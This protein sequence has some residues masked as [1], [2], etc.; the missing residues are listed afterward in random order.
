MIWILQR[1][2]ALVV[3]FR[4]LNGNGMLF[5]PFP[6]FDYVCHAVDWFCETCELFVPECVGCS[7][8]ARVFTRFVAETQH[9]ALT[10]WSF[11]ISLVVEH[12]NS[13]EVYS[14][15]VCQHFTLNSQ[16]YV[17]IC[18]LAHNRAPQIYLWWHRILLL[19][20]HAC[21][22]TAMSNARDGKQWFKFLK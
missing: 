20:T 12:R 8:D 3:E 9:L 16:S 6:R 7:L 4:Q 18:L 21:N 10:F 1:T 14:F 2:Y 5:F 15:Y 13:R 17:I 11:S 19:F 22:W